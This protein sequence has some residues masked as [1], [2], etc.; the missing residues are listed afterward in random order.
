MIKNILFSF[1][2]Y[3]QRKKGVSKG[4]RKIYD[5][6]KNENSIT[7]QSKR[8]IQI[9]NSNDLFKNLKSIYN[10]NDLIKGKRINIGGDHSMTIATGA[11]TLNNYKEP[12]FLWFDAHADINNYENSPTKNYHGMVLSYLSG[13]SNNKR[14]DFIKKKLNL[15]NLMYIGLRDIDPYEKTIIEKYN[16]KVLTVNDINYNKEVA[17]DKIKNFIKDSPVHLSFDVDSMDPK[18]IDSTGTLVERGLYTFQTKEVLKEV[19]KKNVVNI[20]ICEL[21][22]EIG[23]EE[24]SLENILELWGD[25]ITKS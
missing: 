5:F 14:F 17:I 11:H 21:N 9:F 3:G 24:K 22:L 20:D 15:D 6:V 13:I 12:K 7:K 23:D 19:L 16:I 4:P 10:S 1:N 8:T 25:V 18:Y 2:S